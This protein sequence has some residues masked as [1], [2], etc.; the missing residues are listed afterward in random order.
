MIIKSSFPSKFTGSKLTFQSLS[1]FTVSSCLCV[2]VEGG[3][4]YEER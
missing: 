2:W 4:G 1:M 3:K